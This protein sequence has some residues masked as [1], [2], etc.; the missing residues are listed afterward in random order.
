MGKPLSKIF[1]EKS[2]T[3]DLASTR[4]DST[5]KMNKSK[6][7]VS[8]FTLYKISFFKKLRVNIESEIIELIPNNGS[9]GTKLEVRDVE[10]HGTGKL[11][12]KSPKEIIKANY[13]E[14]QMVISLK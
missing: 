2:T 6:N 12:K 3:G 10:R 11:A 5:R 4:K 7:I 1:S 14:D 13:D 8:N 9:S